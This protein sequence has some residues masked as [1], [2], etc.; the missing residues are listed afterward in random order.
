MMSVLY[1]TLALLCCIALAE[2]AVCLEVLELAS[3]D[4]IECEVWGGA[5][6]GVGVCERE[7]ANDLFM[8]T[9]EE[10]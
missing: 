5:L 8:G 6:E 7:L 3:T 1:L 10:V 9:R 4:A 2:F